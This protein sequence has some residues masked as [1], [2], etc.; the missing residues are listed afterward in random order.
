MDVVALRLIGIFHILGD[1]GL[2]AG[3]LTDIDGRLHHALIMVVI[4]VKMIFGFF[5]G[6]FYGIFR[7]LFLGMFMGV[8]VVSVL[9]CRALAV[10]MFI[11]VG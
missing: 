11:R 10:R 9:V 2:G 4:I 1:L 7:R 6:S 5:Y 3:V 8:L